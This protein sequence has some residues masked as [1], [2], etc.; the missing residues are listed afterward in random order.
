MHLSRALAPVEWNP[1]FDTGAPGY[2]LEWDPEDGEK[3]VGDCMRQQCEAQAKQG[4][5]W[6]PARGVGLLLEPGPEF[7]GR[8]L[9]R[10]PL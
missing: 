1:G 10:A 6:V 4:T 9:H 5:G 8:P 7:G 2:V 3:I